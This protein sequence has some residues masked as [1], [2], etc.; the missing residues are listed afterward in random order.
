MT[1]PGLTLLKLLT[2]PILEILLLTLLCGTLSPFVVTYRMAF[3]S[4][5]IAH[6]A[7]TGVALG[8]F[9]GLDPLAT[10][11]VF[12]I[13]MGILVIFLRKRTGAAYDT[14]I[15]VV[16]AFSVSVGIFLV[17][18]RANLF[19]NFHSF[20]YGDVLLVGKKDVLTMGA[21]TLAV[22]IFVFRFFDELALTGVDEDYAATRVKHL[23][24][25]KYSFSFLLA[26][27]VTLSIRSVGI[28]LVSALVILPA[29]SARLVAPSLRSMFFLSILFSL[30]SGCAGTLLSLKTNAST[31]ASVVVTACVLFA[32]C[33]A[34]RT[35]QDGR[36]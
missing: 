1:A 24:L 26:L 25:L 18:S 15:G 21:L 11:V 5:A 4:D 3:F 10:T 32:A 27:V 36:S 2:Y 6:S 17:S 7:F 20:L 8:L 30:T 14:I 35:R 9:L 23:D 29:A 19:T 13:L 12:G 31:G 16:F 34:L 33:A 28:L 22:L